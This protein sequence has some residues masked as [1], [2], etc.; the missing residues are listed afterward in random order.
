MTHLASAETAGPQRC[1]RMPDL[2]NPKFQQIYEEGQN[3]K[4]IFLRLIDDWPRNTGGVP[5]QGIWVEGNPRIDYLQV[6]KPFA[7]DVEQQRDAARKWFSTVAILVLPYTFHTKDT[8]YELF[9][10]VD[11]A[12]IDAEYADSAKEHVEKNLDELLAIIRTASGGVSPA[13]V[14]PSL[15]TAVLNSNT[16][17][18]LMWEDPSTD[19]YYES[20]H[21]ICEVCRNFDI[22]TTHVEDVERRAFITSSILKL[23]TDSEL[24]IAD[25]TGQGPAVYYGLGFAV[26]S[27]KHPILY[28]K[29][30]SKL[31]IDEF[32][33][34]TQEYKSL[35]DM[36][37]SLIRRLEMVLGRKAHPKGE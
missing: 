3:L 15:Q 31:Y 13:R 29:R 22:A 21:I 24:V 18:V 5:A 1:K 37:K 35:V 7:A 36:K 2:F 4:R 14:E 30:N 32:V 26:A 9:E 12:F 20:F 6:D 16:A 25:L 33:N 11:R 23:I 28:R 34:F 10:K 17:F 8:L 27:N 19:G